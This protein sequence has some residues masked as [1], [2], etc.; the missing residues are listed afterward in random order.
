MTTQSFL[1]GWLIATGCGLT[2]H[3]VRGGRLK[4]LMFLLASAWVAFFLGHWV[5]GALGWTMFRIGPLNLAS[6]LVGTLLGLVA[7]DILL[8]SEARTGKERS[9]H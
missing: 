3:L 8:G 7:A 1:F 4:R 5:G 2:Y 9:G 6:A